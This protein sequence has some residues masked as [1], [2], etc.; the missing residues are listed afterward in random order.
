MS[1]PP[2]TLQNLCLDIPQ[3]PSPAPYIISVDPAS[4]DSKSC[5]MAI[6]PRNRVPA[7]PTSP[8][9]VSATQQTIDWKSVSVGVDWAD[10]AAAMA[11]YRDAIASISQAQM[12]SYFQTNILGAHSPFRDLNESRFAPTRAEDLGCVTAMIQAVRDHFGS[13]DGLS[14]D[15]RVECWQD[16][17]PYY[18]NAWLFG[19][20][21]EFTGYA[22]VDALKDE[23]KHHAR[24]ARRGDVVTAKLRGVP[25]PVTFRV[26]MLAGLDDA[27]RGSRLYGRRDEP[28]A[29]YQFASYEDYAAWESL[30]AYDRTSLHDL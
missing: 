11:K 1:K 18:L 6:L 7:P 3:S 25:I 4:K 13:D 26:T 21:G 5:G 15:Y 12:N 16:E 30:A 20:R 14:M 27:M 23:F 28:Q 29:Y 10:A 24:T 19:P 22:R 2:S 8:P 17:N 9:V